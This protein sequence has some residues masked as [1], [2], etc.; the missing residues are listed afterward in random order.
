MSKK[1]VKYD[2]RN[3]EFRSALERLGLLEDMRE[4]NKKEKLSII[5]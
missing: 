3:P 4:H 1:F 2:L 5:F